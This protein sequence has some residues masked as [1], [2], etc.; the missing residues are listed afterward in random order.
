MGYTGIV[1][2]Q[3]SK[4]MKLTA[5]VRLD[6]FPYQ[7]LVTGNL[8][9]E[10]GSV[11]YDTTRA[12]IAGGGS[13]SFV[14][15]AGL[16]RGYLRCTGGGSGWVLNSAFRIAVWVWIDPIRPTWNGFG[17]VYTLNSHVNG[18]MMYYAGATE[19]GGLLYVNGNA[20]PQT[21]PR[22]RWFEY[23]VE[24]DRSNNLTASVNGVNVMKVTN[25][26]TI[27]SNPNADLWIGTPSN[28]EGWQQGLIGNVARLT[29][30]KK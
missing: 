24:R 3:S 12:L 22:G 1:A 6:S 25:T 14:E 15:V 13:A 30:T 28:A 16:P 4:P 27:N 10:T 20:Y 19:G 29:I 2:S 11:L 17:N 8:P 26:S 21:W 23:V 9:V 5:D 18:I 7:E